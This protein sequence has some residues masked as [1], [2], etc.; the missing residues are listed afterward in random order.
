MQKRVRTAFSAVLRDMAEQSHQV[1][2]KDLKFDSKA[3]CQELRLMHVNEQE[4][5]HSLANQVDCRYRT[6]EEVVVLDNFTW[7]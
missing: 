5:D 3:K 6:K 2:A 7:Q 1:R 4:W